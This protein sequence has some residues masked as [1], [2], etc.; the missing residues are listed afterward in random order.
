M[1]YL[2]HQYN[3]SKSLLQNSGP[4]NRLRLVGQDRHIKRAYPKKLEPDDVSKGSVRNPRPHP[5]E[6]RT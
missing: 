6:T 5:L 4:L 2:C 1:I 3:L